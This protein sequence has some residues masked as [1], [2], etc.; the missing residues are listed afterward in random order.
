MFEA[1]RT[2]ASPAAIWTIC[3]VAL[4]CLAFWLGAIAF[5]DKYP[6]WRAQN[7]PGPT[8]GGIDMA[9]GGRSVAPG[10][11]APAVL[12]EPPELPAQRA[13]TADRPERSVTGNES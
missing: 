2:T 7:M 3:V 10:R 6:F 4:G 9:E 8:L 5:A 1:A 12:A 11:D 13:G